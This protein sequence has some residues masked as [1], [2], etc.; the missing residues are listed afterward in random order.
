MACG[1]SPRK[2]SGTAKFASFSGNAVEYHTPLFPCL[3]SRRLSAR[4]RRVRDQSHGEGMPASHAFIMMSL[5]VALSLISRTMAW[6]T[7][8]AGAEE[9]DL[10]GGDP[11]C[12]PFHPGEPECSGHGRLKF[13]GCNCQCYPHF[14]GTCCEIAS[15]PSLPEPPGPPPP[16]APPPDPGCIEPGKDVTCSGHGACVRGVCYC[17]DLRF[18]EY[19][20]AFHPSP[21]PPSPLSPP[22]N[23]P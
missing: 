17:Y 15:P 7:S 18:G 14:S 11:Q 1:V 20:E 12:C 8:I 2:I 21:P 23:V 9:E 10:L 3:P 19:C 5:S 16:P 13:W 4:P 22:P 6:S